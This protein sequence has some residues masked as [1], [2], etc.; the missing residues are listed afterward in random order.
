VISNR[1]TRGYL[2][3]AGRPLPALPLTSWGAAQRAKAD[4][5]LDPSARCLTMFPRLMSW[6]YPIQVVQTPRLVVILFE[7]D[8]TFREI[9]TDD[10]PLDPDDDPAWLGHSKGRWEGDTLVVETRGVT[11]QAWLEAEGVPISDQLRVSERFRLFDR[12]R[13]LED[14]MTI[15]DP[16]VLA[17][18]VSKRLVYNLK[19]DWRL[20]EY[21]CE[22]GNRDD[23][24]HPRPGNPGSLRPPATAPQPEPAERQ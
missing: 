20:K 15:E 6:P 18:P 4:P 12:G 24:G 17:A 13:S 1:S 19:P 3:S 9:Y 11:D 8:T 16:K 14:L 22:E 2:D 21:V 10:R 5:T 7:A 23:V